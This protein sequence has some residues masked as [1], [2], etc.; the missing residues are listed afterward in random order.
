M[1]TNSDKAESTPSF[2]ASGNKAEP[3]SVSEARTKSVV[4]KG[5]PRSQAE[6]GL[7]VVGGQESLVWKPSGCCARVLRF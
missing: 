4:W 1:F 2:T 7:L 5:L 3:L 6:V